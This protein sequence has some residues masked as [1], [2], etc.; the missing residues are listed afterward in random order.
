[1]SRFSKLYDASEAADNILVEKDA[2][3]GIAWI[4]LNRPE[5]VNALSIQ[6]REYLNEQLWQLE[7]DDEVKVVVLKGA[8]RAFTAGHDLA[9]ERTWNKRPPG[10][11]RIGLTENATYMQEIIGGKTGYGTTLQHFPKIVIAQIHGYA[12]GGGF[13][14]VACSC[15]IIVIAED[16][17]IGSPNLRFTGFSSGPWQSVGYRAGKW[18]GS[19]GEPMTGTLAQQLGLAHMVVPLA[20]LQATTDRLAERIARRPLEDVLYIKA[21]F[22][23]AQ[24]FMGMDLSRSGGGGGG[25]IQRPEEGEPNFWRTVGEQGLK[26]GLA[27]VY[28]AAPRISRVLAESDAVQFKAGGA[29]REYTEADRASDRPR[30]RR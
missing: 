21:R 11:K 12:Y 3:R 17:S 16:A 30:D 1:M 28:S 7:L 26:A 22:N 20:E 10:K 25:F 9:E 14:R 8:G 4:T 13:A 27:S 29:G 2:S 18:I 15:D 5:K 19:S 6:M 23:A 24:T